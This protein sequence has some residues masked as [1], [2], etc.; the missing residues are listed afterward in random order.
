MQPPMT[1]GARRLAAVMFTD[2]VGSTATAQENEPSALQHQVEQEKLLRPVFTK[3]GGR[4]VKSTGDGFLV[5]FDSALR[6]VEC[7]VEAQRILGEQNARRGS[8]PLLVRIGIHLGDVEHRDGDIF[9]DAVNIAARLQPLADPG[10][11]CV[12]GQVYD[13]TRD[14][15][16]YDFESLGPV[17]LK[18]VKE[19]QVV[20]RVRPDTQGSR[21]DSSTHAG[22]KLAVLPLANMS[23]EARDEYFSDG[24]TEEII[25]A[26]TKVPGLSV[27][28]RTSVMQYKTQPKRLAEIGRELKVTHILEGSV[29]KASGNVRITVQLIDAPADRHLWAES[30]DRSLEDVF[31]VQSEI[32]EKVASALQI[33]LLEESRKQLQRVPTRDPVAL[34]LYLKGRVSQLGDEQGMVAALGYLKLAVERDPGFAQAH[35]ELAAVYQQLGFFEMLP[36]REAF[37]KAEESAR[38]AIE[39]DPFFGE[40]HTN[41]ARTL[42]DRGRPAQAFREVEL[43]LRLAPGSAQVH[44]TAA[45]LYVFSRQFRKALEE[46]RRA[47]ELDPLSFQ[48]RLRGATWLL[49]GG[50]PAEAAVIYED[51]LREEPSNIF[52]QGNL[53]LCH[54]RLGDAPRAIQE[55]RRSIELSKNFAPPHHSDLVYALVT[56]G[57][58]EE[59]RRETEKLIRY[60]GE[61]GLGTAAIASC[62]AS[63]GEPEKCLEWLE[64]AV[65]EESG[66]LASFGTEFAFDKYRSDPRFVEF[67]RRIGL[68]FVV[69]SG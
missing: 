43:G 50:R 26:L 18:G 39:I 34:T 19:P 8:D 9:G 48:A 1:L 52:G 59:A 58:A 3:F 21:G 46:G 22:P 68:P 66:Y 27:I 13:Q 35:S 6:A 51:L 25:A 20:Y 61:S 37:D 12:S 54:L 33:R 42:W 14:K 23:P 57:E 7:G 56:G 11:L 64:L 10:G 44:D 16:A 31:S 4:E 28:S 30:Y 29:R 2:L 63:L 38:R 67:F 36:P 60:R 15:V 45:R 49:Y 55:L 62:F 32:A 69:D 53:G 65:K 5:E 40:A 47:L 24:M 17:S 41:L